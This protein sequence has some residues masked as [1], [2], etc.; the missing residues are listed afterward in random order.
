M[1]KTGQASTAQPDDERRKR[2]AAERGRRRSGGSGPLSEQRVSAEAV[3]GAGK[4]KEDFFR[5]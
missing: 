4:E 1:A 5:H 2:S 3:K